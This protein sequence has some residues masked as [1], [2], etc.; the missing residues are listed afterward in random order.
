MKSFTPVPT[1]EQTKKQVAVCLLAGA[2][3]LFC[4]VNMAGAW[5]APAAG[6]FGYDLYDLVVVQGIQGA[7]G[8]IGAVFLLIAGIFLLVRQMV[9]WGITMLLGAAILGRADAIIQTLGCMI[10]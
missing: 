9:L 10:Q 5:T 6:S 8:F 1:T 7:T 3:L 2:A 4:L